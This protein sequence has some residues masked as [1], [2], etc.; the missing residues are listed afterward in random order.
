[1]VG[2]SKVLNSWVHDTK[3]STS[4]IFNQSWWPG[5]SE[6]DL[7][8]VRGSNSEYL[9]AFL[10][11]NPRDDGC[12]KHQLQLRDDGCAKHQLQI[13]IPKPIA[14]A[15][16][17]RNNSEAITTKVHEDN[18]AAEYVEFVFQDQYLGRNDMWR[19][20]EHLV[21][22]SLSA[23]VTIFIQVCHELW[24]FAGNG[25]RYN[26][27]DRPFF[28]TYTFRQVARYWYKSHSDHCVYIAR[29]RTDEA[30]VG[31][32]VGLMRRDNYGRWYKDFFKKP[33]LVSLKTSFWDFQWDILLMHHYHQANQDSAIGPPMQS[34]LRGP[35]PIYDY[36][37]HSWD[38]L[39]LSVEVPLLCLTTTWLLDQGF[40]LD[41]VLLTKKPLH[42]SPIFSFQGTNPEVK[43]DTEGK[44]APHSMDPLWCSVDDPNDS[45]SKKTFWWEPFWVSISFGEMQLHLPFREDS[46]EVPSLPKS[47]D[48][49]PACSTEDIPISKAEADKFDMVIFAPKPGPRI[50]NPN[51]DS[52]ASLSGLTICSNKRWNSHRN[53]VIA[54]KIA[55]IEESPKRVIVNL[56]PEDFTSTLAIPMFSGLSTSPS[57]SS[58]HSLCSA[59]SSKASRDTSAR[60]T[61]AKLAPSWL[62]SPFRSGASEPQ[63]SQVS[64]SS[65]PST[66]STPT[67][68]W[69]NPLPQVP[70]LMCTSTPSKPS[71]ASQV[72]R[73]PMPMAIKGATQVTNHLSIIHTF[74]DDGLASQRGSY[75]HHS[76]LNSPPWEE[77]NF[78]KCCST[79]SIATQFSSPFSMICFI[80]TSQSSLAHHWQHMY[81][82]PLCMAAVWLA[83][84]FQFMLRAPMGNMTEK[85]GLRQMK[86]FLK[87]EDLTP[88]PISPTDVLCS[89]ADPVY[90][91][92]TNEI[93]QISYTGEAIQ[94][95]QYVD[96]LN[97][98]LPLPLMVSKTMDGIE[99]P[100]STIG[101]SGEKHN[102]EEMRILGIKKLSD[103]LTR[104][105]RQQAEDRTNH[106][107][108]S[109]LDA[110][111]MDQLEQLNA[112]ALCKKMKSEREIGE[113]TLAVIAKAMPEDDDV[114]IKNYQW[115]HS[116]Y[117]NSFIGY[118]FVS[119]LGVEWGVKLLE[120]GLFVIVE[121]STTS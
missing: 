102:D 59:I 90:L 28:L 8:S 111:L 4:V 68:T 13:S 66:P 34:Y 18:C 58:I 63:M 38:R 6:G 112:A 3:E 73:S 80:P 12:A 83:Q 70:T 74:D 109:V 40:S 100:T 105:H 30:D 56:P 20:G 75:I 117:P 26:E 7:L 82:Q 47:T 78:G 11:M 76:P 89:T 121:D 64:A 35:E 57:Q 22:Q 45:S 2:D 49:S 95:R 96:T 108:M 27:Q 51:C 16:R 69:T 86:S 106:P 93:H 53:S 54:S 5:I 116:Q 101:P 17:L 25:E 94:V 60:G 85:R 72:S 21:G 97:Y 99:P 9:D 62:F 84:G 37:V 61:L 1:M 103:Q 91:S 33:T 115:H 48:Y 71:V 65:T 36:F 29:V 31:Y 113:M 119:W 15:F 41:M 81:P 67:P 39:F 92:M 14:E 50:F 87:E 24:E 79:A 46:I 44:S 114:P 107:A 23:K 43:T 52:V 110:S 77:A 118:D 98:R 88:K 120:Q 10:F 55:P 104:L 19:L 42:Q 32:A